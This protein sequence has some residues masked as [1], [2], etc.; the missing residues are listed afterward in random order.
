M[1]RVHGVPLVYEHGLDVGKTYRL[2]RP[3]AL[4]GAVVEVPG[5]QVIELVLSPNRRWRAVDS[6]M[7]PCLDVF[8][9][10][11]SVCWASINEVTDLTTHA[12]M[13]ALDPQTGMALA[14]GKWAGHP[15]A[16][17]AWRVWQARAAAEEATAA[18]EKPP[19]IERGE[20]IPEPPPRGPRR[21][22]PWRKPK[23]EEVNAH[24]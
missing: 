22:S 6:I 5:D 23:T 8:T 20:A 24:E 19:E 7:L 18:A 12:G 14:V 15:K 9:A 17:E 11:G 4:G 21:A 2:R 3:V 1:A 13:I 16:H 10:P